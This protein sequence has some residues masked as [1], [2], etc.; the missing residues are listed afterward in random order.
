MMFARPPYNAA[1]LNSEIR[2][3]KRLMLIASMLVTGPALAQSYLA[4]PARIVAAKLSEN[5]A[6]QVVVKNRA[7]AS[8]TLVLLVSS[9]VPA[10]SGNELMRWGRAIHAQKISLE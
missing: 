8:S 2:L 7:D 5:F 6:Q 1:H 9:D 3:M 4:K 10:K